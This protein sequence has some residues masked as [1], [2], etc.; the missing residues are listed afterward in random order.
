MYPG[1]W[2]LMRVDSV[3]AR[4]NPATGVILTKHKS[5]RKITESLEKHARSE[6]EK[7]GPFYVFHTPPHGD[8]DRA[9]ELLLKEGLHDRP[10]G[11]SRR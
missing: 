1:K 6:A 10:R 8:V 5:R 4:G 9:T 11:K 7:I 2:V 3:D